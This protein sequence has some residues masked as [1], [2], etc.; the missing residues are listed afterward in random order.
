[1]F[2][3]SSFELQATL[4]V[5]GLKADPVFGIYRARP[6]RRGLGAID[7]L[8]P[9][10]LLGDD[11]GVVL[12]HVERE[13][14]ELGDV[15]GVGLVLEHALVVDVGE[16]VGVL[17][18]AVEVEGVAEVLGGDEPA[19]DPGAPRVAVQQGHGALAE[20]V[21][22][23]AGLVVDD[24]VVLAAEG[25]EAAHGREVAALD[26]G[27]EE[28]AALAEADGVDGGRGRE[29]RVGGEVLAHLGDLL[30]HVPVE[31]RGPVVGGALVEAHV[32]DEGARVDLLGE[33][34]HGL[35]ALC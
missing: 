19:L 31:G 17:E 12:E 29:D 35:Q 1:M 6:E 10:R 25:D 30:R 11:G 21:G 8:E 34:A 27:P 9:A 3:G 14:L 16:E 15:L 18:V 4:S 20:P 5:K 32:V 7:L 24:A 13:V 22:R 2:A 26:V 28:L 23:R 33:R